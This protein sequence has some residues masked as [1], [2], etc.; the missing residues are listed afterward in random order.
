MP[1]PEI[2]DAGEVGV[3]RGSF[4]EFEFVRFDPERDFGHEGFVFR[5]RDPDFPK[6]GIV[7]TDGSWFCLER[8]ESGEVLAT[9]AKGKMGIGFQLTPEGVFSARVALGLA[10]TNSFA[11]R[12]LVYEVAEDGSMASYVRL[13]FPDGEVRT[14][15]RG[16]HRFGKKNRFIAVAEQLDREARDR[17]QLFTYVRQ[18]DVDAAPAMFLYH[19]GVARYEHQIMELWASRLGASISW[20]MPWR[21]EWHDEI[22]WQLHE[23]PLEEFKTALNHVA[24][25]LGRMG[26]DRPIEKKPRGGVRGEE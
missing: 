3:S 16:E 2:V 12:D 4:G 25:R 9:Y 17:E 6:L 23:M 26:T 19:V 15:W 10:E 24:H 22:L 13:S 1:V 18:E 7:W 5:F 8:A 20:R 11:S 21:V 14:I